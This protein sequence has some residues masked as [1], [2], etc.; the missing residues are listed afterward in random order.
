MAF[1][2]GNPRIFSDATNLH[3]S[4]NEYDL[5]NSIPY[6]GERDS[7][8]GSG[9]GRGVRQ[10]DPLSLYLFVL[11]MERLSLQLEEAV[12][13]KLIHPINFR[14]KVRLSHL[15]FVDDIFLFTKAMTRDCKNLCQILQKF[16]PNF[17]K[18]L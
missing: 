7:S 11:C 17:T 14:A 10:G 6:S 5:F 15:F 13:G 16:M 9:P 4:Y 2:L 3:Y 1:Y 8:P 18:I 12:H